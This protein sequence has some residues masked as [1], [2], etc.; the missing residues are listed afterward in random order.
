MERRKSPVPNLTAEEYNHLIAEAALHLSRLGGFQ[1]SNLADDWQK[2]ELRVL[3]LITD[4]GAQYDGNT[5][6]NR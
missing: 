2:A 3:N 6:L 1:A 5:K 4:I